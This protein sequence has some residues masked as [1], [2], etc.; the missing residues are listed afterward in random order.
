M[1]SL[2]HWLYCAWRYFDFAQGGSQCKQL[3]EATRQKYLEG[4]TG[5]SD[6]HSHEY[7]TAMALLVWLA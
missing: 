3:D 1:I 6:D 4:V 5:S 2:L 7:Y